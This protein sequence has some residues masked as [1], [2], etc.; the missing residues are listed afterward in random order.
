MKCKIKYAA[1]V[2]MTMPLESDWYAV[3]SDL[4]WVEPK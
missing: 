3:C 2:S 4:S 1:T